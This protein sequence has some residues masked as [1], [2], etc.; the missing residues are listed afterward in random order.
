[1]QPAT[2]G[3]LMTDHRRPRRIRPF[4]RI[5]AIRG[6]SREAL[7]RVKRDLAV[8]S[9]VRAF[10]ALAILAGLDC[11]AVLILLR[12]RAGI[13]PLRLPNSRLC[14][15]ALAAAALTVGS[16]WFLAR[17]EHE[18][19]ALWIR[20]LLAALSVLP[21]VA[22]LTMATSRN[23]PWAIS[24]VSALAVTA[25][26]VNLL[27]SRRS[28]AHGAVSRAREN[29]VEAGS[30]TGESS[31]QVGSGSRQSSVV[32][33]QNSDEFR[34]GSHV[35]RTADEW[36]ERAID[37]AGGVV[38]R[39]RRVA[40]FAAGQS[41]ATVHIPFMPAFDWLPEFLYEVVDDPSIRSRT[42]AVYRYGA[43]VELR[44]TGAIS[45]PIRVEIRFQASAA[46]QSSRAA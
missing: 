27:W 36:I 24:L 26:N 2:E 23:S 6:A 20:S 45:N 8:W 4:A 15:A 14:G 12:E 39:G 13:S 21:L 44:R 17:I 37:P 25:G 1:M 29:F 31:V 19:P 10:P 32:S 46:A 42:P 38:C 11:V 18:K 22:L 9:D 34:N 3:M 28:V 16:R 41:V 7:L 35:N 33:A 5:R 40:R 30:G 43:R